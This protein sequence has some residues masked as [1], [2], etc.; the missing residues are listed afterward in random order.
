MHFR[1]K[2]ASSVAWWEKERVKREVASTFLR[3][4]A[5]WRGRQAHA[6]AA[7]RIKAAMRESKSVLLKRWPLVRSMFYKASLWPHPGLIESCLRWTCIMLGQVL[8]PKNYAIFAHL[9]WSLRYSN[10][11]GCVFLKRR[12]GV[13]IMWQKSAIVSFFCC[14][15][16]SGRFRGKVSF[17]D[18]SE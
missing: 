16:T 3:R 4:G 18:S 15:N 14:I 1:C 13:C 8:L 2:L 9:L 6:Q 5:V 12:K 7:A 11:P 10:Q 17:S